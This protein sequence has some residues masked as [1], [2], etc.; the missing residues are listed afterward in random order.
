MLNVLKT[1]SVM[2][3]WAKTWTLGL[4]INL[5]QIQQSNL[6]KTVPPI[7]AMDGMDSSTTARSS[8][9]NC[10]IEV[11]ATWKK[12]VTM[13]TEKINTLMGSNRRRLMGYRLRSCRRI[14]MVVI[15]TITVLRKSKTPST[16]PASIDMELVIAMMAILEANRATLATKLMRMA[17]LMI[18]SSSSGDILPC[19]SISGNGSDE[20]SSA[21][22]YWTKGVVS[23]GIR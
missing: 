19:D 16:K 11:S 10:F 8:P 13:I 4:G 23:S 21:S 2:A 7:K 3:S 12:E 5:H 18:R 14:I 22:G 6:T 20:L 17:T 9:I 1:T 15:Q